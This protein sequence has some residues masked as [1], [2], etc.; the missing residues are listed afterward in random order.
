M[1]GAVDVGEAAP[2]IGRRERSSERGVALH[3]D[4]ADALTGDELALGEA[5]CPLGDPS[6]PLQAPIRTSAARTSQPRR[7]IGYDRSDRG[8]VDAVQI[9]PRYD[10]P[11]ILQVEAPIGDPSVP[12]VRQRRRLA[13]V[14][15]ALDERQW[16]A[17]TRCEGW[18]VQDVIMHLITTNQF[19]TL[20]IT[21]RGSRASRRGCSSASTPWQSPAQIVDGMRAMTCGRRAGSLCR[22]RRRARRRGRRARRRPRGRRS[23][24]RRPD[25]SP[26]APSPSTHCGT[27]GSTS[28]TSSLPLGLEPVVEPTTK[29]PGASCMP[30]HSVLP[31]CLDGFGLVVGT[32]DVVATDPD[33]SF[34]VES[35]PTVVVIRGPRRWCAVSDRRRGRDARRASASAV[36]LDHAWPTKI[37]GCWAAWQRSSTSFP[38]RLERAP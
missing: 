32:L 10:G 19:W 35:G 23:P 12:L 17:A 13:D 6:L 37:S 22:D 27:R 21:S 4:V 30:P 16:T 33:L 29:W 38:S 11:P 5:L 2:H 18:S 20:S 7:C 34:V 36:P 1:L 31:S 24:R 25:T 28:A 26:Y 8:T 14:L 3:A 15:A 9:T